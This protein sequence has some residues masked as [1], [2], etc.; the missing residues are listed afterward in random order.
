MRH[1]RRDASRK[2]RA[3]RRKGA[4][5][6]ADGVSRELGGVGRDRFAYSS[7][8]GVWRTAVDIGMRIFKGMALGNHDGAPIYAPMDGFL[9]GIARDATFV[10]EGVKLLEIDPRGRAANWTGS[11]RR[12]RAIAEA[13]VK[14][15]RLRT[16]ARRRTARAVKIES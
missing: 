6:P 1:R 14:A 3:A 13:A 7:R 10:P 15:I 12:G 9:R 8:A 11:D 5:D 4:T 2:D 16:A